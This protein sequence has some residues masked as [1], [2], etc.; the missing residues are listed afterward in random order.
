MA[1]CDPELISLI[2]VAVRSGV[3]LIHFTI[4]ILSY[5]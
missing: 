4:L 3:M 1:G 5:Y 2:K